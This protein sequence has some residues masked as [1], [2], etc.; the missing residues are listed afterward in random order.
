MITSLAHDVQ[1][2]TSNVFLVTGDTTALVDVGANFDVVSPS[3]ARR[4]IDAVA[5]THTHWDHVENLDS[6]VDAFD[7]PV[8]ATIRIRRRRVRYRRR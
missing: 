4:R 5:V 8:S 1:A 7:V 6:V 3:R 2:F